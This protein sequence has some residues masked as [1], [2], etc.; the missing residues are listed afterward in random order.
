MWGILVRPQ[1]LLRLLRRLCL[2]AHGPQLRGP[3]APN[4]V[5]A[6]RLPPPPPAAL[7]PCPADLPAVAGHLPPHS[8]HLGPVPVPGHALL[9]PRRRGAWAGCSQGGWQAGGCRSQHASPRASPLQELCLAVLQP[10]R[11]RVRLPAAAHPT[12]SASQTLCMQ[13]GSSKSAQNFT[14]FAGQC[15][16]AVWCKCSVVQRQRHGRAVQCGAGHQCLRQA[17]GGVCVPA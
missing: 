16:A 4:R 17:L 12:R 6:A 10:A 5:C 3:P 11:S 14:K 13:V 8:R 7:Q 9:V 2:A 15:S 1:R